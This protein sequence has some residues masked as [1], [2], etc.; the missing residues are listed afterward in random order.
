MLGG[1]G[2]GVMSGLLP[3]LPTYTAPFLLYQ[4]HS[5]MK[6]EEMLV[7]WLTA[8]F[9]SQFFGS[10]ATITTHIPGEE[11]AL[12]YLDDLKDFSLTEKNHLLYDTALSSWFA[13]TASVILVWIFISFITID[14][15]IWIQSS[16]AQFLIFGTLVLSFILL[17][18]KKWV[19]F[20][21]V[22]FGLSLAP[23]NNYA[24][25]PLWYDWQWLFHGY[26]FYLIILGTLVIPM[27]FD[28]DVNHDHDDDKFKVKPSRLFAWADTVKA[29][30][31]GFVCGLVPGPSA[32]I[33][34]ISAYRTIGK[35]KKQKI[36]AAEAANNSAIIASL[37]PFMV[38]MLP[39][40][41]GAII[42]PSIMDM[43]GLEMAEVVL[44]ESSYLS[45]VRVIDFVLG[46]MLGI[47]VLYYFLA[48][49]LIDFYVT[50]I[51]LLHGKIKLVLVSIVGLLVYIDITNAEI[52]P[53]HYA[54][55]LVFFTLIGLYLKKKDISAV[56]LMFTV[57]LG[58]K[59]I[60]ASIATFNLYF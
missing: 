52:T 36:I 24:L 2:I 1:L 18:K 12:I 37:I 45:D 16:I 50:V 32:S 8:Y 19:T 4:M 29:S 7:F 14:D 54:G 47:T 51:K 42:M 56:P 3:A 26:T 53:L 40:N 23:K 21:I 48:T 20:A 41:A 49:K 46:L 10:I 43:Q 58:D 15:I 57:L 13:A 33:G 5:G 25:P 11:S 35:N 22:L 17:S 9:G 38:M 39:I 59:L 30:A 44:E 6:I 60:W 55:L 28:Y 27:L 34:S 31:L